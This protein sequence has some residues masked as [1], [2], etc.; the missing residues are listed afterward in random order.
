MLIATHD[1]DLATRC[2]RRIELTDGK[3]TAD[4]FADAAGHE[5]EMPAGR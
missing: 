5:E 2:H 4:Q 3:I 1:P